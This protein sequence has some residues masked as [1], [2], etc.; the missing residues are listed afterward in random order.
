MIARN[1]EHIANI[2]AAAGLIAV[3]RMTDYCTAE[4][5]V[6]GFSDALCLEIKKL[7]HHGLKVSCICSSFI[8]KE[9]LPGNA[10][11]AQS[12]TGSGHGCRQ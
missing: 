6:V 4:L 5:G 2:A 8:T 9:C 10:A 7:G 1:A 12:L 3:L 11:V